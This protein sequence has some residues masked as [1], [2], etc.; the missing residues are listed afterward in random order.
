MKWDDVGAGSNWGT[1]SLLLFQEISE[2]FLLPLLF[3]FV[4]PTASLQDFPMGK[5][6]SVVNSYL[7]VLGR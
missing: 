3:C 4:F 2:E 7:H 5:F 6:K 1:S